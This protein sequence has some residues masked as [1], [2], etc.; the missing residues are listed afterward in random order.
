VAGAYDQFM[1]FS[2]NAEYFARQGFGAEQ[3]A[4]FTY[5]PLSLTVI[6]TA[7]IWSVVGAAVLLLLLLR[8]RLSVLVAMLAVA[9]QLI[10]NLATFVLMDR[11][12]VFGA[13]MAAF[14]LSITVAIVCQF[15][16][17]RAMARRGVLG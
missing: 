9:L 3:V 14:D 10:L 11:W 15:I 1:L 4:Y 7:A 13:A 12:R 17:A 16:Y 2:G 5:Y 8:N 6:W